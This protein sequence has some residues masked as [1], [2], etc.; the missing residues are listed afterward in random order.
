MLMVLVMLV[1]VHMVLMVLEGFVVSMMVEMSMVIRCG[2]LWHA[3][4]S[5]DLMC[6]WGSLGRDR[7]VAQR[8][9]RARRATGLVAA[10]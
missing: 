3:H 1:R 10:R 6:K 9:F 7:F 4:S 8:G 5:H 2:E